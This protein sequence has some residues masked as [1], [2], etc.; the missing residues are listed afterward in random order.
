MADI[1]TLPGAGTFAYGLS[2]WHEDQYRGARPAVGALRKRARGMRQHWGVVRRTGADTFQTGVCKSIAG[3]K[4]PESLRPLAAIVADAHQ[5]PWNGLYQIDE[6]RY[7]YIAVRDANSIIQEGDQIGTREQLERVRERHR[8]EMG[9]WTEYNGTIADLAH[10]VQACPKLP[11]ALRNLN[12]PNWKPKAAGAAV[13]VL[14]SAG[15]VGGWFWHERRLEAQRLADLARLPKAEP[16]AE[17]KIPPWTQLPMSTEV[18][19]ACAQAWSAQDLVRKGWALGTWRCKAQL[20]A[21]TI[22][23]FW[24]RQGGLAVDAPGTLTPDGQGSN[25]SLSISTAFSTPAAEVLSDDA[26]HRMAWTLAQ[27]HGITL[28]FRVIPTPE[29]MPGSNGAKKDAPPDPWV[30]SPAD[31]TLP[32]APWLGLSKPFGVVPALRV[33]EVAYDAKRGQW[34]AN[35]TLYGLRGGVA[36]VATPAVLPVPSTGGASGPQGSNHGPA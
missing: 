20:R 35:G 9:E 1:L 7:W 19:D 11:D 16:R 4:S 12:A 18:F 22:D 31:F 36:A 21:I 23:V 5:Q 17:V 32:Y 10:I 34:T 30:V 33:A 2:W 8:S 28:Q 29:P 15:A 26:A 6:N 24:S 25:S 3:V 27:S 13:G 14:I